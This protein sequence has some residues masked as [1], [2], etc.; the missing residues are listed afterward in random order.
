MEIDREMIMRTFLAESLEQLTKME[1][2]LIKLESDPGDDESIQSIFRYMH[3]LKGNTS[4]LG[5]PR[6]AEFAHGVEDVLQKVKNKLIPVDNGLITLLLQ[7]K[8]VMSQV[9]PEAVAG[10]E[11]V[12][13]QAGELLT[14]LKNHIPGT[15]EDIIVAGDTVNKHFRKRPFGRRT[16]DA[17]AWL[18]QNKTLRVDI[19]KLDRILNLTGEIT[20]ARGRVRQM[21]EEGL[22]VEA[23]MEAQAMP[24]AL[25]I[26]LQ[27]QIMKVRMVPIGPMFQRHIRTVR[28]IA[29]MM[30]KT[31]RLQI[32]GGDVEV[33]TTV[34]E[35][36]NDPL[37]HMIR[38]TMDHGIESP[39]KRKAAGK[40]PCGTVTLRAFH[41]AGNIVIQMEDDGA[42]L[43]R[44][45]ILEKARAKGLLTEAQNPSDDEVYRLIFEPGFS[46]AD[47]VTDMSGRGVGMDVVRRN[48]ESLR[49][50]VA[51]ES[52]E[53]QGIKFNMRLPLTMAIIEGF[54]VGVQ[55]ETC[56]IP[57]DAVV[58][59]LEMPAEQRENDREAGFINLRGEPLP[60]LRLRNVFQFE[61][62]RSGRENIVIVQHAGGRAG[63]AV[64]LL[65]GESQAVIKPLGKLF[66]GLPG[67][68]GSTIL[69]NGRVAL[70]LDVPSLVREAVFRASETDAEAKIGS[71]S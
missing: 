32:E 49:G 10:S 50:T 36:L 3:T 25:F 37:T 55:E 33:D 51:L 8:D 58:E 71:G 62:K 38:N 57:L 59:C 31:A 16:E 40:D 43:N 52:R 18:D 13:P 41:D 5:F 64:D 21:M 46:T 17:R 60:Y 39:E 28:D 27:E 56:V 26:E 15:E 47:K 68:S 23:L 69:G 45:R 53:G 54:M 9:V 61:V 19:A 20:I 7:V 35:H 44:R 30:G 48:I 1:D 2:A 67:V 66:H 70:I 42:G 4:S 34:I 14:R 12:P 63:L 24:D 29:Q 22:S 6:I 65:Y 11:S